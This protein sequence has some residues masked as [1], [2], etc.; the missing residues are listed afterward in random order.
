MEK[1]SVGKI[2]DVARQEV[3]IPSTVDPKK[4]VAVLDVTTNGQ[5]A[6]SVTYYGTKEQFA[7]ELGD[8]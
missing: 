3:E 2:Q 8:I 1:L 4:L 7:Q 6:K 5:Y